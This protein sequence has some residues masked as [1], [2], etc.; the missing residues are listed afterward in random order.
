MKNGSSQQHCYYMAILFQS[1]G[2]EAFFVKP[3]DFDTLAS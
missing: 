3:N 2:D 1:I